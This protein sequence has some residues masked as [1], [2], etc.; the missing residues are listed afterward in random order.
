MRPTKR[1][2]PRGGK[3]KTPRDA[4]AD[5]L[6]TQ[7]VREH[8]AGNLA[9]AERRY[10][11]VLQIEP[12]HAEALNL[13]GALAVQTGKPD[14]GIE[15]LNRALRIDDNDARFHYNLALA[16]QATGD[17][18]AAIASYRRALALDSGYLDRPGQS[19]RPAS[20]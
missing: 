15:H 7:A 18:E 9:Q 17:H 5:T 19:G 2:K 8:R 12:R 3:A 20:Q 4:R 16:H 11:R 13:M 10:E 14:A 6:F 1:G